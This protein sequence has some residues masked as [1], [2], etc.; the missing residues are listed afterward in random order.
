MSYDDLT[1]DLIVAELRNIMARRAKGRPAVKAAEIAAG[2]AKHDFERTSLLRKAAAEGSVADKEAA[3]AQAVAE[4]RETSIRK[5]AEFNHHKGLL[6][7]LESNQMAL[8]SILK[9]MTGQGA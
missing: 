8:Q 3:A 5:T 1:P 9:Y 7:D 4:L 6:A 2:D